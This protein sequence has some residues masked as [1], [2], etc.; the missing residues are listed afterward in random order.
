MADPRDLSDS[1]RRRYCRQLMLPEVGE[2][3]QARLLGARVLLVGAG[4]LGSAAAFYLAAAGVGALGIVDS[5]SVDESNLQRQILHGTD[6]L[7]MAK[8]ES[9]RRTL[10]GLNPGVRVDP[11]QVR[12]AS[13][14]AEEIFSGHDIIL[15]A[16]DNFPTRYL[17]NDACVL[18]K[19]PCVHG[20]VH[21]FEGY[22]TVFDPPRGPCY[23]CLHPTPP[24]AG[25]APPGDETGLLGVVPG[26]IG[27]LQAAETMKWILG[28]GE[29]LAGRMVHYDALRA[30]FRTIGVRRDPKCPYCGDG[31]K[32]PGFVDYEAFCAGRPARPR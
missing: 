10:L 30:E 20:S 5:D 13:G 26:V 27:L 3:G 6:R 17:I 28:K 25:A 22:A 12:L 32:F 31:V 24:P 1:D 16:S 2:E 29:T 14:N 15:D 19:K 18:L 4:G 21:R 8:A 9:A 7:G 11:I 23:R